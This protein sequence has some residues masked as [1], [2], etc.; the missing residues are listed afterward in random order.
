MKSKP[1]S[2]RSVRRDVTTGTNDL[3]PTVTNNI[4]LRV[5]SVIYLE[6]KLKSEHRYK[7]SALQYL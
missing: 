2:T 7:V 1:L 3:L 5:R 4:L 6:G